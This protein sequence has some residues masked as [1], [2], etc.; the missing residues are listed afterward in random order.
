MNSNRKFHIHLLF[1]FIM[2]I[3]TCCCLSAWCA[4]EI[5]VT[6][7]QV[8]ELIRDEIPRHPRGYA[9]R[10]QAIAAIAAGQV[11]PIN[12]LLTYENV[13]VQHDI[14]YSKDAGARGVLDLYQ[15][16]D[17]QSP[18]IGIVL[19]H[20][21]GW[22]HGSKEDY[23]YYG[24]QF[25]RRGFVV[26]CINYRLTPSHKFPAQVHDA[27]AAVRW[28]RTHAGEYNVDPDRIA[29]MGGSAGG[30]LSQMVGYSSGVA[31]LDPTD[32]ES[33]VSTAVQGVVTIYGPCHLGHYLD[34]AEASVNGMIQD[35]LG[36][37]GKDVPE[38]VAAASP[39]TYLDEK[40]PPTLIMHGTID[41]VVPIEQGDE[42]AARLN[43]L[44]IPYIYDRLPGWPHAMDIAQPVND[45][46]VFLTE[47][48]LKN[49]LPASHSRPRVE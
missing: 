33:D 17:A 2:L 40:D 43:E 23:T 8:E 38:K 10:E 31:V 39:L 5:P 11:A 7:G 20:G 29:V 24:Q 27:K 16:K 47:R 3:G 44:N 32:D 45:R 18:C 9:T 49:A 48:F 41:R 19:I 25:A 21:G 4:D 22:R 12:T 13:Q 35:F 15:P 42:L 36:Q 46:V 14:R 6:S 26:A 28:L 1:P 30:H 37:P 34:K